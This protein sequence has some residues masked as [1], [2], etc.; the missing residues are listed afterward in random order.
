MTAAI[1]P[2]ATATPGRRARPLTAGEQA[3]VTMVAVLAAV[4]G[5]IG[6][7]NSFTAVAAAARP[8]FGPLA[9]TVPL[10][11]DLG[12]AI[13]AALDITLARLDMR[14]RWVPAVPWALTAATVWLNIAGQHTWFARI[15]HAVLPA[16][17]V[18]GVSLAAHVVRIRAGLAAGTAIDRIR[19]SRWLLAP[20]ADGPADAPD[21]A[22][23]DP[24]LP[25][26]AGPGTRPA[27]RAHRPA[28]HLRAAGVA[29]AGTTAHPRPVPARRAGPGPHRHDR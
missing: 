21:G 24:L 17:W 3:A 1:M 22:V 14:P 25:R 28:R 23:G 4:L 13:F 12:I 16:L 8:S 15:A 2:A 26:R 6:F 18:A 11:I 7:A 20:R 19:A 5:L 10:G 27:P 29:V 9:P